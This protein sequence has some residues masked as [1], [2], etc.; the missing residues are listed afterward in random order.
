MGRLANDGGWIA[1]PTLEGP[2]RMHPAGGGLRVAGE[3][4]SLCLAQ[5]DPDRLLRAAVLADTGQERAEG[6]RERGGCF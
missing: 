6:P 4:A 3:R 1:L 5:E 2:H